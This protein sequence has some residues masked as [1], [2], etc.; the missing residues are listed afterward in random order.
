M[1]ALGVGNAAA[2]SLN[3]Y[4]QFARLPC[5]VIRG[6]KLAVFRRLDAA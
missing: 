6:R 3:F 2:D 1:I 5:G 4:A